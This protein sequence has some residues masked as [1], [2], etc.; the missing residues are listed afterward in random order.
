MHGADH[1]AEQIA[2]WESVIPNLDGLCTLE[3]ACLLT[4]LHCAD[5]VQQQ[6]GRRPIWAGLG[7]RS[8]AGE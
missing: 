1:G 6:H 3:A 7:F 5:Q 4:H 2:N 8:A